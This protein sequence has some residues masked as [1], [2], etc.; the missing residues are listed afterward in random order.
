MKKR[1]RNTQPKKVIFSGG[2][3]DGIV[4]V[5]RGNDTLNF[6]VAGGEVGRYSGQG[7]TYKWIPK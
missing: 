4:G 3:W 6:S 5:L 1:I 2:P 7:R